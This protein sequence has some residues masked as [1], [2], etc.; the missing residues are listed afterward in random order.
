MSHNIYQKGKKPGKTFN[1]KKGHFR[2]VCP[3]SAQPDCPP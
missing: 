2:G 1:K 3:E